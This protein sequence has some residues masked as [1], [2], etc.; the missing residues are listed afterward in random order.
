MTAQM[1]AAALAV[2][3]TV[4]TALW[5]GALIAGAVWL[6][7][8]S[9]RGIG[10]ATRYAIWLCALIA[11]VAVPVATVVVSAQ[12]NGDRA[13][14]AA[15]APEAG[16]LAATPV[17]ARTTTDPG[18]G[19]RETGAAPAG[20]AS[21]AAAE[22]LAPSR[23]RLA[24][25]QG[26]AALVALAWL[27]LAAARLVKLALAL[28]ELAAIRRD[29][30]PWSSAHGYPVL[31][32]ERVRVPLAFGFV[33]PAVMLPAQLP[34]ELGAE[35]IRTIVV[36]ESAHL[37][38][39]DVWTNA[40][41]RVAEALLVLDP[42]AWFVM[43]R[44]AAEREIACDDCVVER[45]GAGDAFAHVLA[46]LALRSGMRAPIAAAGATGPSRSAIVMRIERLLDASPLRLRL[47][48]AA[49]LA[50]LASLTA[51]A[52]VAG[53]VAPVLAY[54]PQSSGSPQ[55]DAVAFAA[56]DAGCAGL[57]MRI[58][59]S[60]LI[61]PSAATARW[62]AAHVATFAARLD[63]AGKPR[64][65][66]ITSSPYP[67]LAARLKQNLEINRFQR[68]PRDCAPATGTIRGAAVIGTVHPSAISTVDPVYPAGW[69]ARHPGACKIP[70]LLHAGVPPF[71]SSVTGLPPGAEYTSSVHVDVDPS[72][73][74]T[75]ATITGSSGRSAFDDATLAAARS[76]TYPLAGS[77]GFKPVRPPGTT[78]AWNAAHGSETYARCPAPPGGYVWHTTFSRN[79]G[80]L[81]ATKRLAA[82]GGNVVW[83]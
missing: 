52:L 75:G 71:P 31:V 68:S 23:L 80:F 44:L 24:I 28:R 72:G 69:S 59:A 57:H 17:V 15:P 29:A 55:R 83:R 37:R 78:L 40:L 81:L 14:A 32:S 74:A 76:A 62:G 34:R 16:A 8:R 45:T 11:M 21:P 10:A 47:S 46:D 9:L 66:M 61:S 18:A 82:A 42:A 33:R 7:L 67:A 36:H 60:E 2:A 20:L 63:A 64:S 22:P 39:R 1:Q 73:A 12:A 19:A 27:L 65:I 58:P 26:L 56:G 51:L 38:R 3:A 41:A 79:A 25:P 13:V 30:K 35:A 70:E 4:F 53:S 43:R 77:T 48:P 49:L 50:A 54:A 6:V 5:Q